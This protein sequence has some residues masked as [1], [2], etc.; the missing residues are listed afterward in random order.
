MQ[1][2]LAE[3]AK[4]FMHESAMLLIAERVHPLIMFAT[5]RVQAITYQ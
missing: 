5:R 1:K 3:A 4:S 2:A